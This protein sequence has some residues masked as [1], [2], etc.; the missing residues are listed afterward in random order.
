MS[1]RISTVLAMKSNLLLVRCKRGLA[2]PKVLTSPFAYY[3][4]DLFHYI[5]S[6]NHEDTKLVFKTYKS[7]FN[8]LMGNN[9]DEVMVAL[10]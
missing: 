3:D 5:F 2:S 6:Y 7:T 9:F 1:V 8:F 10:T 4:K